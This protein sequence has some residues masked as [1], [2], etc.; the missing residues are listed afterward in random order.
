MIAEFNAENLDA[1]K[2]L[3]LDSVYQF[4]LQILIQSTNQGL[5]NI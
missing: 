3:L 4:I 5:R 2:F 1:T